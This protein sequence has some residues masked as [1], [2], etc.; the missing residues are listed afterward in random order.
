MFTERLTHTP[1][2][3]DAVRRIQSGEPGI[4]SR[5]PLETI[6]DRC[7]LLEA[8]ASDYDGSLVPESQWKGLGMFLSPERKA[9][10]TRDREWY[11]QQTHGGN[12]KATSMTDRDW[13]HGD[14]VVK[15]Q[16]ATEG[17][18]AANT[19]SRLGVDRVTRQQVE[20][21]GRS[22]TPRAGAIDLLGLF[23]QRVI[24]SFGVEQVIEAWLAAY[25][26]DLQ[27][28]VA[29]TRLTFDDTDVIN[30]CH[31]QIVV[32]ATKEHAANRFRRIANIHEDRLLVLGDSTVDVHMMRPDGGVNVLIVPPTEGD[33][34]L[35][36]FRDNNLQSMWGNLT[37]ILVSDDLTPL[38]N[39]IQE[40]CS[41]RSAAV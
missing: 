33:K 2:F 24:I 4:L 5:V 31:M 18:W 14:L 9:A 39:L 15:N 28:A 25:A 17:A 36:D 3:E 12:L 40:A 7:A 20:Q 37:L 10:E 29:A 22:L 1:T 26:A 16:L 23:E 38:V 8:V 21:V 11:W 13:L 6:F 32:S 27:T 30:G 19:I 41:A 34:K 35:K